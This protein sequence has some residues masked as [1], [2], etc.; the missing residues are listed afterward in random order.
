MLMDIGVCGKEDTKTTASGPRLS[1]S[2]S[3]QPSTFSGSLIILM[4]LENPEN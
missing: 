1:N 3:L 4:E 2:S